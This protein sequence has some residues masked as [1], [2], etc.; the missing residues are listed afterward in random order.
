[1]KEYKKR[2]ELKNAAKDKLDGK[3]GSAVLIC[4]LAS[5]LSGC[6]SFIVYLYVPTVR[7]LAGYYIITGVISLILNWI[8]GIL[9][10]GITYF[11]LNASCG[12]TYSVKDLFY[13]FQTDTGKTL[14][15]SAIR[16]AVSTLC[17]LP[18]SYTLDACWYAPSIG[19]FISLAIAGSL[20]LCLY[21]YAGLGLTL[22]FFLLLDFPEQSARDILRQSFLL[23]KGK[24]KRLLAL[25]L[26]FIPLELLCICSL[27]IGLFWL[28]PYKNMTYTCFFLDLMNPKEI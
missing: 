3:Y 18:V 12:R 2:Y 10:L 24:R 13:G 8:L 11:F 7:S 22:A 9:D 19:G 17:L 16:A 6:I 21:L 15:I 25:Q 1:M 23:I 14:S 27:F 5:L 20:C 4:F 26:S 28:T